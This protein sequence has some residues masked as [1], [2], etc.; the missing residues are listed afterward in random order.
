[1]VVWLIRKMRAETVEDL[2]GPEDT[3]E[4]EEDT[5]PLPEQVYH[6]A[7]RHYLDAQLSS[8]DL[9]D[10]RSGQI[11]SVGSVALPLTFA[12]LN[13]GSNR[14]DIPT[15]A[16]WML[17]AGLGV[18][19]LLLV[20]VFIAGTVRSLQYRP[21]IFAL[22]Q[23]SEELPGAALLRWVG[24]E[25]QE[26]TENNK[27]ALRRKSWWVG[28]ATFLLYIEGALLAIAALWTLDLI[29]KLLP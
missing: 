3:I 4:Y 10:T 19:I 22:R 29:G 26:S 1:M 11:F 8:F 24:N 9:L 13:L 12:L 20:C 14:V 27:I 7:A 2:P 28:A 5:D 16:K 6:D 25:Y 21:N 15:G 23:Y 18:Y 17:L